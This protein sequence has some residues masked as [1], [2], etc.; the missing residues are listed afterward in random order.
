[1]KKVVDTYQKDGE[2]LWSIKNG[3]NTILH[4]SKTPIE[5]I[6]ISIIRFDSLTSKKVMPLEFI[7]VIS[8]VGK[9]RDKL[10]SVSKK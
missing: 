2:Q 10:R 8:R 4:T 7:D 5:N 6:I 1:M 9:K 3:A